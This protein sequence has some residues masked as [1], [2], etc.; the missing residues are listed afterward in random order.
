M[1][2]H[3]LAAKCVSFFCSCVLTLAQSPPAFTDDFE[4]AAVGKPV[5]GWS[6]PTAGYE[7]A[8]ASE[9]AAEGKQALKLHW[10]E[11][12]G[13]PFGNVMRSF[14][15]AAFA[16]HHV[17]L[18]ANVR[19]ESDKSG[20]AQ[21]WLRVD[22]ANS[23]KGAFD[24][25]GDRPIRPGGWV[26]A[27]IEADV[28]AD[29]EY[30]NI[31]FMSIGRAAVW[32][33]S[34]RLEITG[35]IVPPQSASPA[36]ELSA[37]GL[38]NLSA[39]A[40]LLAY[41]RFFD[42]SDQAVG[43]KAWD[44]FAVDLMERV[45]GA[46]D[47][48]ELAKRLTEVFSPIAPTLQVWAG[49]AEQAPPLEPITEAVGLKHWVHNGVG[50]ISNASQNVYSSG[51]R[52][53]KL[54]HPLS[55]A[56]DAA[57]T[58]VKSLPGGICCRLA[59]QVPYD[60]DGTLPH[61]KTPDAWACAQGQPLLS[62]LNRS[63]RLAGVAIAWG[64]FQ[65]F[66]PYFDVVETDWSAALSA[67][68]SKAAEDQ[69][70]I[71]Y[72]ATLRELVAKL[73]DGHGNVYKPELKSTSLL[74]IAMEWAGADL[75]IVGKSD[76]VPADVKIGD[77][78]VAI[79]GR[80]AEA[81]YAEVSERISAATDGWRRHIAQYSLMMDLATAD[82]ATLTL[83]HPD[84][85][86]FSAKLARGSALAEN[87][88]TSKRPE[89]G[90]ELA[91]G[92]VYFDLNGTDDE[93]LQR[94]ASKLDGAHGIVFDMRGYPNS[95]AQTVLK[96][97]SDEP[98]QS[99]RWNVPI[100]TRP[101]GEQWEWNASGRWNLMPLAPRWTMPVAFLTDAGAISYAE[102][103]MGIVEHY[104]LGEIVGSTTAGTNG[105]VNPFVLPGGYR[106]SWTG[107]KVLKHDGSQHHGVGIRPTVPVVPTAR[108][109]AQGRDEVL[110]RAIDVV[111]EKIAAA[112]K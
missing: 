37:R 19:A 60:A 72:L 59:L 111:K 51:V 79:D 43:V 101:D 24:N 69:S 55:A 28:D 77:V 109:I 85:V 61:G 27:V 48:K 52:K 65:H 98:L 75:V 91:P 87:T 15:A 97:L 81:C 21:M 93:A 39:A 41:V 96:H 71:A 32:V 84:G 95:A 34:V 33:D 103:I 14:P 40:R 46:S 105:N 108:G 8:A 20:V 2:L 90:S 30:L 35:P 86:E 25:M 31:G 10:I 67:G 5:S 36:K 49:A 102:S 42:A 58:V 50:T 78:V 17:V 57:R 56:D 94:V 99:A 3:L 22:R 64:I 110:E 13:A 68:L 73:H 107:M 1:I 16:G 7:A 63:T 88:H 11:D 12:Q 82:P 92:I 53:Q 80:S 104:Q 23:Q 38:E 83:E 29:A 62:A 26:K 54:D 44:H 45:E 106:V 66:Y 112:G 47:A 4:Q 6:V 18:S 74:P 76:G 70:E 9:Q 89:N 100:I